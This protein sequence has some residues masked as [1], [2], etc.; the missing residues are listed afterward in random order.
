M[1][2]SYPSGGQYQISFADSF[3]NGLNREGGKN[4][5]VLDT[6]PI[7]ETIRPVRHELLG[8]RQRE[9]PMT[10]SSRSPEPDGTVYTQGVDYLVNFERGSIRRTAASAMPH[11]GTFTVT[12][13]YYPGIPEP[14]AE[15]R[16]LQSGL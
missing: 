13:R 1:T 3:Q 16:G 6:R 2:W 10:A 14:G 4:Y 12:Y 9:F 5:S 11:N 8:A 15:G 7:T